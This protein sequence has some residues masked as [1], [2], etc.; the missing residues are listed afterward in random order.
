MTNEQQIEAW[1]AEGYSRPLAEKIVETNAKLAPPSTTGL[2]VGQIIQMKQIDTTVFEKIP[3]QTPPR[4]PGVAHWIYAV[5]L[6]LVGTASA[7]VRVQHPG[8][9]EHGQTWM[10]SAGDYRTKADLQAELDA[11]PAKTQDKD[12][13]DLKRSLGVQI[14]RLT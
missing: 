3:Q 13:L 7:L 11:L 12:I 2:K 4:T 5:V 6:E 14:E 1:V 10:V 9:I 8:N